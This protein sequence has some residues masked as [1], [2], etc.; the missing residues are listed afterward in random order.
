M[1]L[2]EFLRLTVLDENSSC[3]RHHFPHKLT[4]CVLLVGAA[5]HAKGQPPTPQVLLPLLALDR[6]GTPVSNL[7]ADSLTVADNK[8][9]VS[10]G[11]KLL[12]GADLPLRLGILIDT[13]GSQRNNR[14]FEDA[15]KGVKGFVND[16]LRGDEDRVFLELFDVTAK[17]TPLLTKAQF[18][19]VSLPSRVG[20][21]TALYDAVALACTEKLGKSD[22]ERPVRRVLVILSDGQ[23]TASHVT[24]S[25]AEAFP[26]SLGVMVF[27]IST[28]SSG[29]SRGDSV[30]QKMSNGTG[31][32]AYTSLNPRNMPKLF[33][34]IREQV[35]DMYYLTY[36]PPGNLI[37]DDVHTVHVEPAK[38]VRLELRVPKLYAWNP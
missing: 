7:T 28:S 29:Q 11:L 9:R 34:Q 2:P 12:R 5:L 37:K 21:G 23:D 15:V 33:A 31:G 24:P 19:G 18:L 8:T 35:T 16:T 36:V 6:H 30:L 26:L 27:A 25:K 17:A 1:S 13:S 38:G 10:S 4:I 22:W 20:G 3:S 32:I 14:V